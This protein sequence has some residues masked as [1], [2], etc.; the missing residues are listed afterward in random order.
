MER[1]AALSA[2][3]TAFVGRERELAERRSLLEAGQRLV[4]LVASAVEVIPRG[5]GALAAWVTAKRFRPMTIK[6]R[7]RSRES[8]IRLADANSAT[9]LARSRLVLGEWLHRW[10]GVLT[11][12]LI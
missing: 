4:S 5:P 9:D 10:V 8:I 12:A 6:P 7:G 3:L 11:R 1:T 2:S